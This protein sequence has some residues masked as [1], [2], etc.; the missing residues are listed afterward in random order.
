VFWRFFRRSSAQ[1]ARDDA[2]WSEAEQQADAPD[3]GR[4]AGLRASMTTDASLDEAE[5]QEEMVD[6]LEQL[7]TLAA[8]DDLPAI[9]TQHR[10]IGSDL[11]HMALP[12]TLSAEQAVPGKLFLTRQR[13]VFAGG[14]AR[15]WPWHRVRAV[16]RK[17]RTVLVVMAGPPDGLELQCNTYG[18]AVM[19][20]Y[21]SRRLTTR[22]PRDRAPGT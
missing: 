16:S 14:Q 9:T 6:G 11:C 13:L 2:W 12:A 22:P 1:P 18:D 15:T 7:S 4:I 17:G 20:T 5:Q 3:A 8:R 10:V 21:L 19:V